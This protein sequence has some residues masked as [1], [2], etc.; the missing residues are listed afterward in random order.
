MGSR[1]EHAAYTQ[2]LSLPFWSWATGLVWCACMCAERCIWRSLIS[3]T[4]HTCKHTHAH[5]EKNHQ[6]LCF[7]LGYVVNWGEAGI[8]AE[9]KNLNEA[10]QKCLP[11]TEAHEKPWNQYFAVHSLMLQA[12]NCNKAFDA[13]LLAKM[14][15]KMST[16][17]LLSN[18]NKCL[19]FSDAPKT[20]QVTYISCLLYCCRN[21]QLLS[22]YSAPSFNCAYGCQCCKMSKQIAQRNYFKKETSRRWI[23]LSRVM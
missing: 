5:S 14:Q 18:M 2:H 1:S 16:D 4:A 10:T 23:C 7:Y 15:T 20:W 21:Q 8:W 3:D 22:S 9:N 11:L 13:K 12:I 19:I 6:V 17:S